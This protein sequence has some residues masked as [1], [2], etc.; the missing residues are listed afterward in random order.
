VPPGG[1]R[2]HYPGGL[3]H[4]ATIGGRRVA[5]QVVKP[6]ATQHA[7]TTAGRREV[8]QVVIPAATRHP[9]TTGGRRM[10]DL[11]RPAIGAD[12]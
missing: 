6:A 4:F 2:P 3:G 12:M 11:P 9:T 1:Q 5:T 10:E 8:K 7:T